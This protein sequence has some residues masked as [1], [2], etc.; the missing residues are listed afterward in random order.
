MAEVERRLE[1]IR[2]ELL[3]DEADIPEADETSHYP[4]SRDINDLEAVIEKCELEINELS[5]NFSQLSDT[6]LSFLEYFLNKVHH[7]CHT[8]MTITS[9]FILLRESLMLKNS[10]AWKECCGE[11]QWGTFLSGMQ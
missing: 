11:Y 10:K 1:V 8:T 2:S 4:S 3:K 9:N 7:R 5:E 6:Q